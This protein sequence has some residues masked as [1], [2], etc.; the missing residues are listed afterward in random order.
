[1]REISHLP[2]REK[3]GGMSA[4]AMINFNDALAVWFFDIKGGG[5]FLAA[6]LKDRTI[7]WRIRHPDNEKRW[8]TGSAPAHFDTLTAI[9]AAAKGFSLV[10]RDAGK[11]PLD[12]IRRGE[13]DDKS[14]AH[15]LM[16]RHWC[17][18]LSRSCNVS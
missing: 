13:R 8:F 18:V 1:M 12:E 9:D 15:D 6:F 3:G 10:Y 17:Q 14:F 7:I 4:P 5:D 11:G 16:S 2:V